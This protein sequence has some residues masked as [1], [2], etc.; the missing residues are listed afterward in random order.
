MEKVAVAGLLLQERSFVVLI[1]RK[2]RCVLIVPAGKKSDF[3]D[4]VL[5]VDGLA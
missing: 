3:D 4:A 1:P 2:Q 5:D